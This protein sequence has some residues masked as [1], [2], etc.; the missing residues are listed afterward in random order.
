M[1]R[2]RVVALLCALALLA[3]SCSRSGSNTTTASGSSQSSGG[4]SSSASSAG[5]DT[6]LA[7]GGFGD[8]AKVCQAGD[9]KGATD[10]GVTDTEIRVGTVTDKG[11]EARPELN[12]EMYDAAVAFAKWCNEKGGILG[13]KLVIDDRDAKLFEYQ[14]RITESCDADLSLVGGGA[15]VDDDPDGNRE[16]CGLPNLPGYVVSPTA[17]NGGLQVSAVPSPVYKLN[18]GSYPLM[19]KV[20]PGSLQAYGVLWA[21]LPAVKVVADAD[22]EGV[23]LVGGKVVYNAQYNLL[24]ESNWAPFIQDMKS[25]GVRMLEFVGEPGNL[26]ALQKAMDVAG[27][28]PDVTILSTNF[29]DSKY[30][31]EV[32]AS[33]PNTWIRTAFTPF[34]MAGDNK[35][36]Q[37]Y[38]DLMKQYNPSGKI[39]QLGSQALSA[40]LL[41]AKSATACGSNLTRT[42]LVDQAKKV[43]TWT[44]GG[45]HAET[46]P[47]GDVPAACLALITIKDGK[48]TYDRAATQ[49]TQGIFNCDPKNITELKNDYGVPRK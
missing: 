39:A 27:W 26:E 11:A 33:A 35:A 48:F 3:S 6:A 32:G 31:A 22:V 49:P 19:D 21:P 1:K 10:K 18:T 16:K 34:E 42:C 25:K 8:L 9:A 44:G 40:F 46:N 20:A 2:F 4:G 38:L 24:G 45:L 7:A 13:R 12:R 47:G 28:H 29:Y 14:Q 17:R 36:T 15:A 30:L 23:Q 41:F 5:S 43:T 37:D